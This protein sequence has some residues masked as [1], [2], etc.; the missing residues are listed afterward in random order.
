ME[1]GPA[2]TNRSEQEEKNQ[3]RQGKQNTVRQEPDGHPVGAPERQ[4]FRILLGAVGSQTMMTR[5]NANVNEGRQQQRD[6]KNE[7]P[8]R[9][10]PRKTEPPQMANLVDKTQATVKRERCD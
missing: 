6:S 1:T 2:Q 3:E 7:I 8:N 5:M 9:L 10:K 4:V